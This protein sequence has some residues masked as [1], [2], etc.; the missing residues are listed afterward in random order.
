VRPVRRKAV[1][2]HEGDPLPGLVW[3][4][5][6][7]VIFWRFDHRGHLHVFDQ[8]WSGALSLVTIVGRGAMAPNHISAVLPTEVCVLPWD[9][10]DAVRA[11]CPLDGELLR[12]A[13]REHRRRIN[14][15]ALLRGLTVRPR[16]MRILRRIADEFGTPGEDGWLVAF[17]LT[18]GDLAQLAYAN[19][20]EVGRALRELAADGLLKRVSGRRILIPDPDRLGPPAELE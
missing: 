19:R 10:L 14:W 7:V 12:C 9:A 6:G 3:V 16:V 5:R 4:K 13:G 20:D 15:Q 17:P 8:A 1:A 18:G 2:H 11:E